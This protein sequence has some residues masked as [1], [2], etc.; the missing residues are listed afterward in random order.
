MARKAETANV[1]LADQIGILVDW[2]T[3]HAVIDR[4]VS[5]KVRPNCLVVMPTHIG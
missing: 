5:A 2:M 3:M 1:D 4:S